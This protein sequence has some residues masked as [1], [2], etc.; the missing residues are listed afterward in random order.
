M[1]GILTR[2]RGDGV[3][4]RKVGSEPRYWDENDPRALYYAVIE[5][6]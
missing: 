4:E 3:R 2:S 5:A 6:C 1:N